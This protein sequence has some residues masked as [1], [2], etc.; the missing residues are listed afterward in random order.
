MKSLLLKDLLQIIRPTNHNI[1]SV[2][3]DREITGVSFS[4]NTVKQGHVFF[5]LQGAKTDGHDY[6]NQAY[7]NGC[8]AAIGQKS[9]LLN[10]K[11][12]IEVGDTRKALSSIAEAYYEY[13][14]SK[15]SVI[16]ITGTN[17][18]TTTNWL[19]YNLLN[20]LNSPTIR[21]GTL[22]TEAKSK[23]NEVIISIPDTLTTPDPI[24]LAKTMYQASELGVENCILE[25]SSHALTQHRT[26]SLE[27]DVAIFTNLTRD[28]LD[29]HKTFEEYYRAKK[30]IF[31]NLLKST[32][33][34]RT[35]IINL[36]S[37]YGNKWT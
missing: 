34:N 35:A 1:S 4:S 24:E 37:E 20:D 15:M 26:T 8:I 29:Y 27:L 2:D 10:R 28:H 3:L 16:G 6:L 11:N 22:G 21:F 32:K 23:N 14:S 30:I 33:K 9:D 17:G 5:A 13:P 36:N 18:K 7:E 25:I 12:Y 31:S 19:L